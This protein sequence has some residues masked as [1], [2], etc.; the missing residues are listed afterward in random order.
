M[1]LLSLSF[2][3]KKKQNKTREQNKTNKN[4]NSMATVYE[5]CAHAHV[6]ISHQTEA[7]EGD[8]QT[9]SCSKTQLSY[10]LYVCYEKQ[11]F[12][13]TKP[14]HYFKKLFTLPCFGRLNPLLGVGERE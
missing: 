2:A 8:R 10:E 6:F 5:K 11:R 4:K 7:A 14:N 12:K 13:Y 3:K 9:V 1:S